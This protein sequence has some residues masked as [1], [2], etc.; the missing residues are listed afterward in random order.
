MATASMNKKNNGIWFERP[1]SMIDWEELERWAPR[2][3]REGV[4]HVLYL[5]GINVRVDHRGL[6]WE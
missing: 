3:E 2:V 6:I 4:D 1:C 5:E